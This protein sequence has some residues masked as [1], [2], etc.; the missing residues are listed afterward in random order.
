MKFLRAFA[1]LALL[2]PALLA[3]PARAG[4]ALQ[5]PLPPSKD[6]YSFADLYRLTVGEPVLP[7]AAPQAANVSFHVRAASELPVVAASPYLFSIGAVAAPSGGLL[8][9]VG[10]AAALWVAR[11]RLGYSI[12]G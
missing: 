8:L 5:A 10:L 4:V 9:L 1:F 7:A 3:A 6:L 11:R 12:R 2:V